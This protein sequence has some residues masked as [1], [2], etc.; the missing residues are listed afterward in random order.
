MRLVIWEHGRGGR[1]LRTEDGI[2][3]IAGKCSFEIVQDEQRRCGG[4]GG[5]LCQEFAGHP[6]DLE[7]GWKGDGSSLGL[8]GLSCHTD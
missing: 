4:G 6:V 7:A 2:E 3:A 5:G 8:S 1:A